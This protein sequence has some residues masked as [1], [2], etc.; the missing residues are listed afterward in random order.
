MSV[1]NEKSTE[2]KSTTDGEPVLSL[3]VPVAVAG[4]VLT[5]L[6]PFTF[7]TPGSTLGVAIGGILALANLWAV[8][9]VVRG[10]LRGQGLSWGAVAAMKFAALLYV[11]ALVLKNHWAEAVPLAVGY[12]ALPLGIVFGQLSRRSPA[13]EG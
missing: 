2:M 11:V 8:A 7:S 3:L 5:G 10:F 6:A 4:V 1:K 12:A 13:R 9:A